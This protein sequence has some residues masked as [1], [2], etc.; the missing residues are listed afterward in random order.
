MWNLNSSQIVARAADEFKGQVTESKCSVIEIIC[1]ALFAELHVCG[2]GK[3][4]VS[5]GIQFPIIV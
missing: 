4:I 5:A 3:F 1:H 2:W